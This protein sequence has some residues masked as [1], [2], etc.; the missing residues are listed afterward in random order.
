MK[1]T[2]YDNQWFHVIQDDKWHYIE[3]VNS[4]N[5]AVILLL[6][7]NEKFIFIKTYRKAIDSIVI[8]LPRGYGN[9]KED[10]ISTAIRESF[11]ETGYKIQKENIKKI[12]SIN[13]NSAILSS[14]VDIF[15]AKVS[16]LDL[17]KKHD[18]EVIEIIEIDKHQ[19]MSAVLS[20]KIQDAFSLSAISLYT[21][22]NYNKTE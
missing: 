12:G 9:N 17:K 7:D 2:V 3:E 22:Q 21:A 19:I 11:E 20:G 13:P 15:F 14:T 16:T 4:N 10:S 6:R 5:G 18:D 8:E 1:K